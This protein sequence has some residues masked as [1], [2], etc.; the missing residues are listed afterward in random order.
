MI[1]GAPGCCVLHPSPHPVVGGVD[2]DDV[3]WVAR[4]LSSSGNG[5]IVALTL[6]AA[7]GVGVVVAIRGRRG[8]G[9]GRLAEFLAGVRR[10]SIEAGR[11]KAGWWTRL[12]AGR[13]K[14]RAAAVAAGPGTG[15]RG[16]GA[17]S[18]AA[19][20]GDGQGLEDRVADAPPSR[21][22]EGGLSSRPLSIVAYP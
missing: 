1:P 19:G 18:G 5:S 6:R 4:G 10:T 3:D 9:A 8:E 17:S 16:R 12:S 7:L 20:D 15:S 11:Y 14:R 13:R 22:R 2:D 21:F